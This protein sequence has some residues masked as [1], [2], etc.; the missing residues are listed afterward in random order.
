MFKSLGIS[1]SAFFSNPLKFVGDPANTIIEY[2]TKKMIAEGK[3][4]PQ[5]EAALKEIG[6]I[7]GAGPLVV[8]VDNIG[9]ALDFTLKNLP[10][11]LLLALVAVVA[12]Y[13]LK[14][15]KVTK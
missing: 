6:M 12:F 7:K 11:I 10:S 13:S 3:S 5:I 4:A 15:I 1:I 2:Q 8:I 9:K 14:I